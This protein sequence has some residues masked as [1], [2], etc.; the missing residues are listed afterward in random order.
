M[1]NQDLILDTNSCNKDTFGGN[2]SKKFKR[3][4]EFER[5]ISCRLSGV[6]TPSIRKSPSG[7]DCRQKCMACRLKKTSFYC[8]EYSANLCID[9]TDML[10]CWYRFHNCLKYL[11]TSLTEEKEDEMASETNSTSSSNTIPNLQLL[12]SSTML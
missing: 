9:G 10:N 1:P 11:P 4:V 8:V 12:D 5:D 7:K 3:A 6:H 2:P